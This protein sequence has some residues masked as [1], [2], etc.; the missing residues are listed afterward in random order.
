M[1]RK[2]GTSSVQIVWGLISIIW[3]NNCYPVTGTTVINQSLTYTHTHT[4][5][6]TSTMEAARRRIK[7][8]AQNILYRLEI[9]SPATDIPPIQFRWLGGCLSRKNYMGTFLISSLRN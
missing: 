4:H 3:F 6:H 5:T 9:T 1:D 2:E 8:A 7:Y